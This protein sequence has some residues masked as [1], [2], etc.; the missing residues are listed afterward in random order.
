[1]QIPFAQL[2]ANRI[3]PASVRVIQ[4]AQR[5][6]RAVTRHLE[7]VPM[8]ALYFVRAMLTVHLVLAIRVGYTGYV[9]AGTFGM[10]VSCK[11]S[12]MPIMSGS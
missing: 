5:W 10:T 7:E 9:R 12:V 1:M 6:R 4:Q 2:F 8:V 11:D 3:L